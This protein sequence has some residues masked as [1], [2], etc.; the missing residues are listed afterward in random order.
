MFPDF[1]PESLLSREKILFAIFNF[2]FAIS[3]SDLFK[4]F[5]GEANCHYATVVYFKLLPASDH[6]NPQLNVSSLPFLVLNSN[7]STKDQHEF[8][9][10]SPFP[11]R[12]PFGIRRIVIPRPH[13]NQNVRTS[14]VPRPTETRPRGLLIDRAIALKTRAQHKVNL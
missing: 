5:K 4:R 10:L 14:P 3:S 8:P 6:L 11:I 13:K 12:S 2:L 7:H 9:P 1:A